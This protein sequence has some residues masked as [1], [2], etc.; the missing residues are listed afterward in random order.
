MS[1]RILHSIHDVTAGDWNALDLCG[2]PF[3]R[4]EF[5]AALEDTE[6][7][8]PA[9][10]WAPHH[11]LLIDDNDKQFQAAMPLYLKSHSFGEFVFDFSWAQ[12]FAHAGLDYYPKLLSAIPFTPATGPR[13]LLSASKD[14]TSA[15][16]L[17]QAAIDLTQ[18]FDLSSMHV[19]YADE[20][21]CNHFFM[22]SVDLLDKKSI[23]PE[24]VEGHSHKEHGTLR[25]AQRERKLELD[26]NINNEWLPRTSC[27]FHWYNRDYQN[28]EEFL[29][30]FR[31][32]KR[33][34]A[35]RERRRIIEQNIT[36]KTLHGGDLTREL[37]ETI[38]AFSEHTF[39]EHG[40]EH[41]LNADFFY[42]IAQLTPT[43]LM[44]KLAEHQGHAIAA[45]IFFVGQ[46]TLFGRYWGANG[47]VDSLHFETC[48]YQGIEYCIEHGLQKF[49][50]GT[51]GE[52]KIPR[53]FEPTLTHSAHYIRDE[54]FRA[55]LRPYL[56]RERN[57]VEKYAQ[58]M[59]AHVPFHRD[60]S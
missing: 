16:Q 25:Q 7:A 24:L 13:I 32:D 60:E 57:A 12:A 41:Y 20:Q 21:T 55:A 34:K 3:L 18:D 27:D 39:H 9:T 33:K 38:F 40:H 58:T 43:Q 54:R 2:Q 37:C 26:S 56:Q 59:R 1:I 53:G 30:C 6:C 10:G 31:A 17:I 11:L 28:M 50:P 15:S 52:H 42:R 49:E 4:H 19:L 22:P 29:G 5:L 8:C 23:L 45:A 36:F 47:N 14:K 44:I 35:K 46:D 48:Y 51:Q